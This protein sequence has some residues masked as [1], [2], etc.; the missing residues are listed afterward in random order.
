MKIY[1]DFINLRK[2][3]L[4]ASIKDKGVN[5]LILFLIVA[6]SK[7]TKLP[8]AKIVG[9]PNAKEHLQDVQEFT[10]ERIQSLVSLI[11]DHPNLIRMFTPVT[12]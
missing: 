6:K 11:K 2:K 9:D 5:L 7:P 10:A 12:R 8:A 1:Q 3:L 4:K